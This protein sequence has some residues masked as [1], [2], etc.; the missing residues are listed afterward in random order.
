[1]KGVFQS[2]VGDVKEAGD[3]ETREQGDRGQGTE[4]GCLLGIENVGSHPSDN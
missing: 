3:E 2:G 1:M 4:R